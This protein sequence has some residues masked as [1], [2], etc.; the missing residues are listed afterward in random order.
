MAKKEAKPKHLYFDTTIRNPVRNKHFLRI[1]YKY[2]GT[3]LTNEL[4]ET[5]IKDLIKEKVF[6][7]Q[8]ALK[9][10]D[11]KSLSDKFKNDDSITD[12]EAIKII[13]AWKPTHAEPGFR[14]SKKDPHWA[15]RWFNYYKLSRTFG[16]ID[17]TA[18]GK[19]VRG[20]NHTN[21]FAKKFYI[22]ELGKLLIDSIPENDDP[23]E[24]EFTAKE[25]I[26]YAHCLA[27][28]KS[29]NPFMRRS[30][31]N[32]PLPLLLKTLQL[33]EADSEMKSFIRI[34][35]IPIIL[36]WDNNNPNELYKYIKKFREEIPEN[37]SHDKIEQFILKRTKFESW[38]D[39]KTIRSITD[40]YYRKISATGLI[41]TTVYSIK[42][43]KQQEELINYIVNSYLNLPTDIYTNEDT[44]FSY[45]SNIDENILKFEREEIYASDNQLDNI[46]SLLTWDEIKD[47][48]LKASSG[49]KSLLPSIKDVK[50]SIRYEFFCALGVK[51]QFKKTKV[52]ANCRTDSI[53]WPIGHAKGQSGSNTGADIECFET[54]FNF[55]V[56]PTLRRDSSGQIN[57]GVAISDHRNIMITKFG[58]ETKIIF[59]A[60]RIHQRMIEFEKFL[61]F[62]NESVKVLYNQNTKEYLSNL[63]TLN[64]FEDLM[65]NSSA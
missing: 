55:I 37:A 32:S 40:E 46:N 50:A 11:D 49:K 56:E 29:S 53:G 6:Y 10:I 65:K 58:K 20:K 45:A 14:G 42:L 16:L 60:P 47:E 57:E 48:L 41:E 61:K 27:K 62:E 21:K 3:I 19:I 34:R 8:E 51:K 54:N 33:I 64:S 44:Y 5:I 2:N 12:K 25:N 52:Q 30:I 28:Y 18:P 39:E 59:V 38:S 24:S 22:T 13:N 23:R 15:A 36:L 7:P 26:I 4:C 43:N 35:E 1:A 9:V 17:F 63:E 31:V